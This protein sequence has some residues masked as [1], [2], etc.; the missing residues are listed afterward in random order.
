MR[1]HTRVRVSEYDMTKR[2]Y[3]KL[4]LAVS[5]VAIAFLFAAIVMPVFAGVC[6]A[7]RSE[8]YTQNEAVVLNIDKDGYFAVLD[9]LGE[10]EQMRSIVRVA[11]AVKEFEEAYD[12]TDYFTKDRE[13]IEKQFS[14][15][16]NYVKVKGE[17]TDGDNFYLNYSD[18]EQRNIEKIEDYKTIIAENTSTMTEQFAAFVQADK[19]FFD[20][21]ARNML[22]DTVLYGEKEI[23][24][25]PNIYD[26]DAVAEVE[27][28][29]A[30]AKPALDEFTLDK[31]D[32]AGSIRAVDVKKE[33]YSAM[34]DNVCRNDLERAVYAI[35]DYYSV[36]N[37]GAGEEA[38]AEKKAAADVAAEKGYAFLDGANEEITLKYL[39]EKGV[40]DDYTAKAKEHDFSDLENKATISSDNGVVSVTAY[41]G[42]EEIAV[43]PF[44]AKVVVY[45]N[46]GSIYKLNA[47]NEIIKKDPNVSV[48]YCID[49]SIYRGTGKWE[50]PKEIDGKEITYKV[51]VDLAK[52][53]TE[54][55][56]NVDTWLDGELKK[57]DIEK[58]PREDHIAAIKD[59][60][61]YISEND[62]EAAL[63]Y[64]YLG[65]SNIEGL[66]ASIDGDVITFE[67]KSFSNF[68][69]VKAGGRSV[70][71]SP[72][73]W[74]I[75]ILALVLSFVTVVII[76]ACVKY[77]ITFNTNGGSPVAPIKARKD[78]YFIM[79]KAPTK[80]GYTFGGWFEDKGLNVRFVD[81]CMVKRRSFK[82]Y[83]KWNE[84]LSAETTNQFYHNLRNMLAGHADIAE[85]YEIERNATIPLAKIVN[86][87]IEIKLFLALD[88]ET[89]L[90]E[91][92]FDI[93]TVSDGEYAE[94]PLLK[95]VDS[96]KAYE[97]A[98]KLIDMLVAQYEL[99]ETS[100]QPA[101]ENETA[102]ILELYGEPCDEIEEP[103]EETAEEP[104]V[105]A[106]E[107]PV[108]ETAEESEETVEIPAPT[109]E[110]LLDYFKEIRKTA[111]GFALS[112]K[113][114]KAID[115][116]VILRV[117]LKDDCVEVYLKGDAAALG[118]KEA[119]GALAKDTPALI[120]VCSSF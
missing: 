103:V 66:A 14:L 98:I 17:T 28:I 91:Y 51:S 78:E 119:E 53:F 73:F 23:K 96:T 42:G 45:D 101:E 71:T 47:E 92:S 67:T 2:F 72:L 48:A 27:S 13:F 95:V 90:K 117:F 109:E 38:I 88:P 10:E 29:V 39:P 55:V 12:L 46:S 40:L 32:Y 16:R 60:V 77:T 100:F 83:A 102:F 18:F 11:T 34:L 63:C 3:S 104:A 84:A 26:A 52:Y 106:V 59:C 115:D 82:L 70:L 36:V 50:T 65:R 44:N 76:L 64:H 49:I 8:Y 68:A 79:P 93:R 107:E 74:L 43:F 69:V 94:T 108:E 20:D 54:C 24:N 61:G 15:C 62:T 33:E 81:T 9:E 7:E 1:S 111:K 118:A 30:A 80:R 37:L 19:D 56:E 25:I 58:E 85:N 112:E 35:N 89:V 22:T 110:Q 5:A 75:F 113:N 41:A 114:G 6:A 87:G 4:I 21:K 97:E 105:E 86:D 120:T 99:R 57:Q 31:E 116:A